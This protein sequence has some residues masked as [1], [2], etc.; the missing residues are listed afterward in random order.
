MCFILQGSGSLMFSLSFNKLCLCRFLFKLMLVITCRLMEIF[1]HLLLN[2]S[3]RSFT[4]YVV[5][6]GGASLKLWLLWEEL[7]RSC[8]CCRRSFTEGVIVVGGASLKVLLLWEELPWHDCSVGGADLS[9]SRINQL[10]NLIYYIKSH[11]LSIYVY[12]LSIYLAL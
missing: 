1:Q 6:V 11:I 9:K 10:L 8:D 5:V 4:E 7:H 12:L 2:C 3:G